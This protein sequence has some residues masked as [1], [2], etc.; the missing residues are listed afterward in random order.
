MGLPEE[1]IERAKEAL[2]IHERLGDATGQA[3]CL[4]DLA[5]ALFDAEQLDAAELAASRAIDLV[6]EKGQEYLVCQLHRVLGH[7]YHSKGRKKEA[8]HHFETDLR[9]ASPFRW[10]GQLFWIHYG[11]ARLFYIGEEF[12][13]ANFH[14]ERAKSHAT[15]H[16][17][18]LGRGMEGQAKV[19]YRQLRLEDAESETSS[20]LEIF[21][22]LGAVE[23]ARECRN[24]LRMIQQSRGNPSASLHW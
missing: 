7:T 13:D 18:H 17:Y 12:D 22:K 21:E 6:P 19:W 1:G 3:I 4:K 16:A 20:A 2:K 8:I 14:I 9:I 10:H 11:L 15:D 5:W 24:L 23:G